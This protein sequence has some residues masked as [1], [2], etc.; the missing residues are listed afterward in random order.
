MTQPVLKSAPRTDPTETQRIAANPALSAWV[1]ASAGS[2]KTKVLT[3]RVTRLLL[4]GVR[5]EKILCLTYTRAG[6]AEMANRITGILSKWAV[7]DDKELDGDLDKLQGAASAPQQRSKARR[8]FAEVLSCP[9]G[10]RIRTIHSFCQ[11]I[12]SRFPV[13]AGLPPYFSLIEEQELEVLKNEVLD[14]LLREAADKPDEELGQALATLVTAQGEA[15]FS[16]MLEESTRAWRK[17]AKISEQRDAAK[18][19]IAQTRNFLKL[20]PSD[21]AE[22][23]RAEAMARAPEVQLRQIAKWVADETSYKEERERLFDVLATPK[24]NWA[25]KFDVYRLIFLTKENKQRKAIASDKMRKAHPE[26]DEL[27]AIETL[28]LRSALERIEAA[29]IAEAT[30]HVLFFGLAFSKKLA[31]RKAARAALDYD[32][33]IQFT[34]NLLH[35][36]GIAPWILYKLD[37]GLDH[38]LLDEAQD[39][40]LAQ[41]DILGSL[42]EEFYAG[43][44]ARTSKDRTLFVVGDEKQSI[45]SFQNAD[46][47]AFHTRRALFAHQFTEAGKKFEE[48]SLQTSFRSAPAVLKAVDAVFESEG[49]RQG[50]SKEPVIHSPYPNEDGSKKEGRVEVWPLLK[51]ADDEAQGEGWLLSTEYEEESDPLA[52]TADKIALKIKEMLAQPTFLPGEKKPIGAGDVMILLRHRGRFADL[53]VRALKKNKVPV[54]GVDRMQLVNQLPVMDLLALVRFVLLPEDDLNLAA[55]LRSP[56]LGL[57]EEDLMKVA[58]GREGTLWSSLKKSSFN[59]AHEYLSAKLGE[60]DAST[61]FAFL[62][63]ALNAPCPANAQSGRKA[64]WVRLGDEALDPIEELLNKA[65]NFSLSHPPSLQNF[66]HWLTQSDIEIKRELDRTEGQVRIMTVHASKGLEA[67]IVFLPDT[68][69]VPKTMDKFQW[70]DDGAPLFFPRTPKFGNAQGVWQAARDK[71]MEEYRRLFY[72]A[73]TRASRQLYI[74]GWQ[75]KRE[76]DIAETWYGL[77]EAALKKHHQ[78]HAIGTRTEDAPV[79]AF[80]DASLA[81]PPKPEAKKTEVPPTQLPDWAKASVPEEVQTISSSPVSATNVTTA[82][83]DA[84]YARGRIIHRLLQSLPDI[85]A[86][87]RIG[88]VERFLSHPRHGLNLTQ[89]GEIAHEVHRLLVDEK[90]EVLWSSASLAEAPLAGRINGAIVFRQV[91]R[92]CL[93]EDEVWIVDYKTN[94]PPPLTEKDIPAPYRQQLAEYRVLLSGIYPGKKVR[95]FLLWTFTA[96]LMEIPA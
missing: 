49:A 5:P 27:C 19:L 54:T 75:G 34:E 25:S 50:V 38:I 9:G 21:T 61:P 16:K 71:Q 41:W 15:G 58:I 82:T 64:L 4:S 51:K 91:D 42:L 94:R 86:A 74:C 56:L 12:L 44:G 40:S 70:S 14:D 17:L 2:G 23:F 48:I 66:L 67:P 63:R 33:L 28:R 87:S 20:E 18:K 65:Q 72:V 1:N 30:Q 31:A 95:C 57:S 59:A 32:D 45:F 68:T 52:E 96:D 7:C 13:E 88:A 11:E 60:A 29:D 79:I 39:T 85:P 73:L 84:A 89:R 35:Q 78:E 10:L 92:L 81:P 69:A 83:P 36:K 37:K 80:A 62:S 47:E 76:N 8:L 46:P 24:E 53:M 55:L 77:A 93:K 90:F 22:K 3:D 43:E 26:I 6:A